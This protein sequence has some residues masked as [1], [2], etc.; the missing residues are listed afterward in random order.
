M[1]APTFFAVFLFGST[2]SPVILQMQA[3][4]AKKREE[5][6]RGRSGRSAAV[7]IA[8]R[9]GGQGGEAET[10][11]CQSS[12]LFSPQEKSAPHIFVLLKLK[13]L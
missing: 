11:R 2:P 12:K 7:G 10:V 9:G 6:Q 8:D 3:V 1:D 4:P 5:R 13:E